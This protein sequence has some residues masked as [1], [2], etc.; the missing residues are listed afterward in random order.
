MRKQ[1]D[2]MTGFEIPFTA[3]VVEVGTDEDGDQITA[4]VID[5]KPPQEVEAKSTVKWTPN[6]RTLRRVL[7]T[8]LADH[9]KLETPFIDGPG[10]CACDIKLVRAE[11]YRQHAAEGTEKQKYQAKKKAFQRAVDDAKDRGAI[12]V[13]EAGDVQLIWLIKEAEGHDDNEF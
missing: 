4:Q 12:G 5:W 3:R 10:V 6:M 1:R 7:T 2:G 8:V 13:R 11:F 9:G